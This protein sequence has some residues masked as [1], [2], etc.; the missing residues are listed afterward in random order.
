MKSST[1]FEIQVEIQKEEEKIIEKG[2]EKEEIK[3]KDKTRSGP[4]LPAH[5]PVFPFHARGLGC[6]GL[7][8]Q[9]ELGRQP[10]CSLPLHRLVRPP[11]HIYPST[12]GAL[13]TESRV[14]RS[15]SL[16]SG[17]PHRVYMRFSTIA[18]RLSKPNKPYPLPISPRLG[19][20]ELGVIPPAL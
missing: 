16:G 18:P 19:S 13:K 1:M 11:C 17:I 5:S 7:R 6:V 8:R 4:N 9:L 12:L 14:L 15:F 10:A 20:G 2:K 3:E